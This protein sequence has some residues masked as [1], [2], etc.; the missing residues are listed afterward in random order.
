MCPSAN[1]YLP[2]LVVNHYIMWLDVSVHDAFGV[3]V[4]QSLLDYKVSA[5]FI[6]GVERAL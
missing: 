4:V 6:S 1:C 5:T 3:A 2:P